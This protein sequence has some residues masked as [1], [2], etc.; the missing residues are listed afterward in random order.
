[1]GWFF[2]WWYIYSIF[3]GVDVHQFIT[4]LGLY[5]VKSGAKWWAISM[6]IWGFS[7]ISDMFVYQITSMIPIASEISDLLR[8]QNGGELPTNRKWARGLVN[9]PVILH[10]IRSGNPLKKLGWTN[11]LTFRGMSHQVQNHWIM[12]SRESGCHLKSLRVHD[13]SWSGI[14]QIVW[15]S[16]VFLGQKT[17][18]IFR[19]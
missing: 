11:P 19:S 18:S 1:M 15:L 2:C 7:H 6:K 12:L 5:L 16:D 17:W 3:Y 8:I 13:G 14:S 10:G 9:Y 4:R